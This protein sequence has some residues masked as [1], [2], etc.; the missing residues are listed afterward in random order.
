[1]FII[2]LDGR[3][4]FFRQLRGLHGKR[5]NI[6]KFRT[7]LNENTTTEI[8]QAHLENHRITRTGNFLRNSFLDELPQLINVL[9]GDM[10]L[11]GPRPHEAGQDEQFKRLVD[12]YSQRQR[13]KPGLTG[14]A[15]LRGL[16]GPITLNEYL[17]LRV[18]S[19]LELVD[20]F[21][22]SFYAK[23]L[24]ITSFHVLTKF[25]PKLPR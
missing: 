7:M 3:P 2:S 18:S 14:L 5:F 15:Q 6:F 11:V 12:N 10:S 4:V 25:L 20:K 23:I 24:A 22:L 16:V 9:L 19:D 8:K 13:L 21:S 1:M 17:I